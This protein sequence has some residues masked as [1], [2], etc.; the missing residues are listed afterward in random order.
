MDDPTYPE[1]LREI[2]NA[3]R[4]W[5]DE[6]IPPAEGEHLLFAAGRI[7]EAATWIAI[8]MGDEAPPCQY[9]GRH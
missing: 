1:R 4:Q 2:A 9:C 8:V 6:D 3:V 7:E 5:A